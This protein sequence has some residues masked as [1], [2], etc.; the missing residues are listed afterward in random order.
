MDWS[1]RCLDI[2]AGSGNIGEVIKEHSGATID[3]VELRESEQAA[4]QAHS[5]NVWIGDFMEWEPPVGYKPDYIISNPPFS[6]SVEIAEKCFELF[7]SVPLIMLQRLD[8]LSSKKRKPFFDE[9]PLDALWA[10]SARPSFTASRKRD[11]W[12]YGWF[13]W[14]VDVEE[15]SSF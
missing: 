8:F 11:I 6:K 1:G 15:I 14:G 2:G 3:S 10:L 4:L 7:P 13:M 5:D 9:H 12:S